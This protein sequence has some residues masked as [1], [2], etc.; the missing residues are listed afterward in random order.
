MDEAN[1]AASERVGCVVISPSVATGRYVC[2]KCG[3][4]FDSWRGIN[5]HWITRII[6]EDET[7]RIC[8]KWRDQ[9][10]L[11]FLDAVETG[12]AAGVR[13]FLAARPELIG[14][15]ND[16]GDTAVHLAAG[17]GEVEVLKVL[18]AQGADVDARDGGR[19][20]PLGIAATVAKKNV[21]EVAEILLANGA[22]VNARNINGGTALCSA[23]RQGR[24]DLFEVL[25]DHG[26]DVDGGRGSHC[27]AP[28]HMAVQ[29]GHEGIVKRLLAGG[30]DLSAMDS[31]GQ[32]PLCLAAGMGREG[33]VGLLLAN[34]A[35]VDSGGGGHYGTPL[36]M[37][38]QAEHEGIVRR[39]LA[40]G[41]ELSAKNP[42]GQTPLEM[43]E[44]GELRNMVLLL[45]WCSSSTGS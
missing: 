30:A 4:E 45:R 1:M 2:R 27:G 29:G 13:E 37:A 35:E 43:A 34:G 11:K 17:A 38:V 14:K 20:T 19:S 42:R 7:E 3:E 15:R 31:L 28:L 18:L 5:A 6:D 32:T 36:H 44:E 25:V 10:A 12:D 9:E 24:N 22:D 26:A 33:L 8:P 16:H 39:L 41:A 40:C 23:A 21:K